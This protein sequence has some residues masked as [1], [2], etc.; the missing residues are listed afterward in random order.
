[1]IVGGGC[2]SNILGG[3]SSGARNII[4]GNTRV[5]VFLQ[6]P[7]TTLNRV[8]GN[9]IG[10]DSDGVQPVPNGGDGIVI[11]GEAQ[12]NTIGGAAPGAGN[13]ISGNIGNGIQLQQVGTSVNQV[14][15][16]YIGTD[17]TGQVRLPNDD[18]VVLILGASNNIVGGVGAWRREPGQRQQQVRS[19][20]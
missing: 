7:G 18:G 4:S 16:N 15:G 12:S 1:M 17:R 6:D 5:G 3:N 8:E 11:G 14:L 13:L 10:T 9:Y 19:T 20:T 2:S